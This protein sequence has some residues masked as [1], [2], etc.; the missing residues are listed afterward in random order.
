MNKIFTI[1][2]ITLSSLIFSSCAQKTQWSYKG[3]TSAKNWHKL[4]E[5]FKICK[6]GKFQS[7]INIIP[8]KDVY[9]KPI[10]FNYNTISNKLINNGH[11][12]Q[13]NIEKGSKIILDQKDY[14]LKQFHF[15]TPSENNINSKSFPLEAH[16]V[17]SSKDGKLVVV[18]IMFKEGDENKV[19]KKIFSKL[20]LKKNSTISLKLSAIDIRDLMPINREYYKFIGSLTTPPCTQGVKWNVLKTPINISTEQIKQFFNIFGHSNNRIIQNSNHRVIYK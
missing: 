9:I 18:A 5:D 15:H 6:S 12:L 19:L 8:T 13:V 4:N 10:I 1:L 2:L 17:H 7:P 14:E 3:K 16:Y 20:P 11:T